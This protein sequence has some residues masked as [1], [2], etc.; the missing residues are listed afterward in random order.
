MFQTDPKLRLIPRKPTVH[1]VGRE[2]EQATLNSQVS[3]QRHNV[4]NVAI[5]GMPGVGKTELALKFVDLHLEKFHHVIFVNCQ[6]QESVEKSFLNVART[7]DFIPESKMLKMGFDL[8][9]PKVIHICVKKKTVIVFDDVPTPKSLSGILPLEGDKNLLIVVTSQHAVWQCDLQVPLE[10]FCEDTSEQFLLRHL[11]SGQEGDLRRLSG[12]LGNLPLALSV[13]TSYSRRKSQLLLFKQ[14]QFSVTDLILEIN[15]DPGAFLSF[16]DSTSGKCLRHILRQFREAGQVTR[17]KHQEVATKILGMMA[18]IEPE[19]I[20]VALFESLSGEDG[21]LNALLLLKESSLI[22]HEGATVTIHPLLGSISRWQFN[23][24]NVEPSYLNFTVPS[25]TMLAAL[26]PIL[27]K[28]FSEF[29][30]QAVRV[31]GFVSKDED[32]IKKFSK[33]PQS[34]ARHHLEEEEMLEFIEKNM[35]KLQKVLGPKSSVVVDIKYQQAVALGEKERFEDALK[36]CDSV[37]DILTDKELTLTCH[38]YI[39][40]EKISC[41]KSLKRWEEAWKACMLL[42]KLRKKCEVES[43]TDMCEVAYELYKV[44]KPAAWQRLLGEISLMLRSEPRPL[45]LELAE[46]IIDVIEETDVK[47]LEIYDTMLQVLRKNHLNSLVVL[48]YKIWALLRLKNYPKKAEEVALVAFKTMTVNKIHLNPDNYSPW[49][50]AACF[51]DSV[52]L[53][54]AFSLWSSHLKDRVRDKHANHEESL[55]VA[56]DLS[57]GRFNFPCTVQVFNMIN[58]IVNGFAKT[59][60]KT[61]SFTLQALGQQVRLLVIHEEYES[62]WKIYLKVCQRCEKEPQEKPQDMKLVYEYMSEIISNRE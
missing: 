37:F 31:W 46:D 60:G 32:L 16:E 33:F 48:G 34:I 15:T 43:L 47:M 44:G 62:A 14:R 57:G 17:S 3:G 55:A 54:K 56:I 22:K 42:C 4:V 11:V 5:T 51:L 19:E 12:V 29:S 7:L 26:V 25:T 24:K 52:G 35:A 61:S 23:C 59:L 6:T 8:L 50:H 21:Y 36:V 45:Q 58:V 49:C 9:I 53:P 18:C 13:A 27:E 30:K 2:A 39:L 10:C 20:P 41:L 40:G 28:P 38:D 1:F